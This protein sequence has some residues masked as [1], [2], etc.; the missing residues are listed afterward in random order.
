M[1]HIADEDTRKK[2]WDAIC[3]LYQDFIVNVKLITSEKLRTTKENKVEKVVSYLTRVK[4][5][6]EEL[7][8]VSEKIEDNELVGTTLRGFTKKWDAFVQV[9]IGRQDLAYW[10]RLWPNFTQEKIMSLVSGT[11]RCS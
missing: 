8:G 10:E 1:P 5:V 11:R 3:Q 2:M 4:H 9:I 7:A 6:K